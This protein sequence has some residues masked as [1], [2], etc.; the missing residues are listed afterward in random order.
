VLSASLVVVS[1]PPLAAT[2]ASASPPV[3][4][5]AGHVSTVAG[6]GSQATTDGVGV[7]AALKSPTA[8]AVV[9]SVAFVGTS[10][11]LR[12][13]DLSSGAVTTV[14]LLPGGSGCAAD[15]A[16][17]ARR[18]IPGEVAHAVSDGSV[19]YYVGA[20]GLKRYSPSTGWVTTVAASLLGGASESWIALA[21]DGVMF[22]ARQDTLTTVNLSSGTTTTV[23]SLSAL[24]GCGI[25]SP[26][27]TGL[28]ADADSVFVTVSSPGAVRVLRI[29]RATL[30]TSVILTDSE[31]AGALAVDGGWL[32]AQAG[33]NALRRFDLAG[34]GWSAWAGSRTAGAVNAAGTDAAFNKVYQLA[35]SSSGLIVADRDSQLLRRVVAGDGLPSAQPGYVADGPSF[36]LGMVSTLAGS[37][38]QLTRAGF[39]SGAAFKSPRA[40]TATQDALFVGTQ[41]AIMKVDPDT[42]EVTVL[43]GAQSYSGS[44]V[45]TATSGAGTKFGSNVTSMA[46][47]GHYVYWTVGDIGCGVYRTNVVTGATSQ[48]TG[49]PEG[50]S[51]VGVSYGGDGNLYVVTSL[52]LY[53]VDRASGAVSVVA[54]AA[55]LCG[56]AGLTATLT[57][58]SASPASVFV[59][60]QSRNGYGYTGYAL[61]EVDPST[62]TVT[63]V[64]RS[65]PPGTAGAA[66][67]PQIAV[68]DGVVYGSQYGPSTTNELRF[69][70]PASTATSVVAGGAVGLRDGL[71]VL[72]GFGTTVG[73]TMRGIAAVG[74]ALYVLD[75][76]NHRLRKIVAA[77]PA[78][79]A[80]ELDPLAGAGGGDD[81][82]C[83]PQRSAGDPVNTATGEFYETITDLTLPGRAP[84]TWSRTYSSVKNTT[85]GPLGYGWATPYSMKVLVPA[86]SSDPA[87]VVQATG[88]VTVF[89]GS[90]GGTVFTPR[91][92]VHAT[93][94]KDP[95]TG[96]WTY[97]QT[98][99]TTWGFHPDGRL[100]TITDRNGE[101][102]TL[103]YD[104]AT[105]PKLTSVTTPDGR[106]L[107]FTYTGSRI[108]S[109]TG[110]SA[111]GTPARSVSYGYDTFGNLTSVI[112]PRGKTW[113]YAYNGSHRLTTM[114]RPRGGA[115][116]N[117]YDT[118]GRVTQ[119]VAPRGGT[120][121]FAYTDK[122]VD[123]VTYRSTRVT[124][125][126]GVVTDHQYVNGWIAATLVAAGTSGQSLTWNSYDAAGNTLSTTDPTG[127]TTTSTYDGDGN[128]LTR[129]VP[130]GPA[131]TDGVVAG[132]ATTTWTYNSFG[133]PLSETDPAGHTTTWT[134][135]TA[136]NLLTRS[137]PL[138]ATQ[139]ATTT[140]HHDDPAH[141]GDVT[142]TTDPVGSTT[143]TTYTAAG[144]P[145]S[146]T[147]PAGATA[148]GITD[149]TATT[150][151]TYT[152][153]GE[154]LTAVDPRGNATGAT[155]A[156][157]RTSHTYDNGGL[158]TSTTDPL[159]R[160]T[161]YG[162]DND[163]NRI[164]VTDPA[165]RTWATAYLLDGLPTSVT[166]P[167][168]HVTR[169]LGY[170]LAGRVTASTDAVGN[171]TTTS[172]DDH[173]RA[174][175]S[176]KPSGNVAGISAAAKAARTT[177][178]AYDTAGRLL[179]ASVP[180]PATAGAVLAQRT[181]YD[182]A[183]RLWK[184]T[185]PAGHT[186]TTTYDALNRVAAITAPAGA[187]T[188]YSYD[189]ASRQVSTTDPRGK[190]WTTS[191]DQAGNPT[192]SIDPLGN[193]ATTTYDPAGRRA[194]VVDPRGNA[195]G[196]TPG[197]YTTTYRY[198]LAG[199]LVRVTDALGHDWATSY[200]RAGQRTGSTT[201]AS[202]TTAYDYDTTGRLRTITA[203]DTGVTTYGYD[204]AGRRTTLTDPRSHD[205]TTSYDD[206]GR[207]TAETDPLGRTRSYG[208]NPD[209]HLTTVTTT[210]GTTTRSYD[211]LGRLTG[212]DYS[213]TTPDVTYTYDA[214]G[215]RATMTD[216]AGTQTYDYDP[217]GRITT[218]AR[219]GAAWTYTYD[220]AGNVLTRTRPDAS[221]ETW[222]YDDAS[223][224]ASVTAP[225][226]ATTF[227][228]D[229]AGNPTTTALPNGTT[230]TRTWDPAG[231]L[232][233]IATTTGSTTLTSQT[234]TR[235][236][237]GNPTAV[238]IARGAA[239][240]IR[241]YLYDA[242]DRLTA[243]CYTTTCSTGTAA[244]TWT[245]DTSGNRLT[246][247]AA[248]TTTT[249]TYDNADQIDTVQSGTG[250]V[251]TPGYDTDGNQ[252]S[253][254]NGRTWTYDLAGRVT[255]ATSGGATTGYGYDGDGT[256][257][258][259]A[260]T[261]GIGAGGTTA[262]T[263]D[264]NA[265]LPSLADTSTDPDGTGPTTATITRLRYD[266]NGTG[267]ALSQT[268][269][270]T[271]RWYAHDPL[272]S[273]T[274]LT[275]P[276][277]AITRSQDWTPYGSSRTPVG[278]PA[279]SGPIAALGWT[280]ALP[281][282][283]GTWHLRA[284]QYDPISGQFTAPDPLGQTGSAGIGGGYG[285]AYGYV[286]GRVAVLTDPSGRWFC[287][288]G[289][290]NAAC[291]VMAG[292]GRVVVTTFESV[293]DPVGTY[294]ATVAA[295]NTGFDQWGG[296]ITFEGT[297]QCIDNLNPAAQI[298]DQIAHA[299]DL[300]YLGCVNEAIQEATA[301]TATTA[302]LVAGPKLLMRAPGSRPAVAAN[303]AVG[304]GGG[305]VS[306]LR[307]LDW[308]DDTGS[309]RIPGS[310][311]RL[312]NSQAA[313][314]AER[315]G[316]RP[317][318]YISRGE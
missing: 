80:G 129:T 208:Y 76:D 142:S 157:Y 227:G 73:S 312:T 181:R 246:E 215:Y 231:A 58:V 295:C 187:V 40:L 153:Y 155:P 162:Y 169:T 95:A 41:D 263:W 37:G 8:V 213:D 123:G 112:D 228:H 77:P 46:S 5:L 85:D 283:D 170:D 273:I 282:T 11:A 211:A 36:G 67:N 68:I 299:V 53:R 248:G 99:G 272:G 121:L 43:A 14:T 287:E 257:R 108:A 292:L 203:P 101:T 251:R 311:G 219:A 178:Y 138:N 71:S 168:G 247:T 91:D 269:N 314:M 93:L 64:L 197:D 259:A 267:L 244:Q 310:G 239:T 51:A 72:A 2:V 38:Q 261:V 280:G 79:W 249:Y 146:V 189:W 114:T 127:V 291:A 87:K 313:Q 82:V 55:A 90:A 293:K 226:G 4:P 268:T 164:T 276:S 230:E 309:V 188:S 17:S 28:A 161:S 198:D 224:P 149:T 175:T 174:A 21:P 134:Y 10:D 12:R 27:I 128:R 262:Y 183:G 15:G 221:T 47:D 202:A 22:A 119:Q 135:D 296:G 288:N 148:P 303:T 98:N 318:N 110:P 141:P 210:R 286:G 92:Y 165:T 159:G 317:T 285:T 66:S 302:T 19:V 279:G 289:A 278:A 304:S 78:L 176:I 315:V 274:D 237:V 131:D 48:V 59:S 195:S 242:N 190:T 32:Y 156:D 39:G 1:V 102:I 225:E 212:I 18:I 140:F 250:P 270:S 258:S 107:T 256:R 57:A 275:D 207:P 238:T 214:D 111:P 49:P 294:N 130:G 30:A 147:R 139:T 265:A 240:E 120:T 222:T 305:L 75:S 152:P 31:T 204:S 206:A 217:A 233:T 81:C 122:T 196:A 182:G 117:T 105:P 151:F 100:A 70:D 145:A 223:R 132:S 243:V 173:G 96:A 136:G 277:G 26:S 234:V 254:G 45:Q 44:C 118:A 116:V 209:G 253:D 137:V 94:T 220:D 160:T 255:T 16:A 194:T 150:T 172:Y 7:A 308:A 252:T 103:G 191:Y 232:A 109:V 104:A 9:G 218:I 179:S 89:A 62:G 113:T 260:I 200:D 316:Y 192:S 24:C 306:R 20:C 271:T 106:A 186:T 125:P 154:V 34:G 50:S 83:L 144:F 300:A 235:D 266:N 42:T 35:V 60:I 281:D 241:S 158:R 216:G 177:T 166:D 84:V 124:D 69:I 284:R 52:K 229:P 25:A 205:W 184:Q 290:E 29:A 13:V 97:R 61:V 115:T 199:H 167:L 163:G 6:S 88:A 201:P 171:L 133:Q 301:A 236:T 143:T 86:T 33:P 3:V 298:R 245:Y 126:T 23:G 74:D 65:D 297:L 307:G 180:D 56:C 193:T 264:F 54:T 63:K 185:D